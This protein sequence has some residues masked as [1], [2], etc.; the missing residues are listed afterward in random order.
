MVV[1]AWLL[2][3]FSGRRCQ[4]AG[5]GCGP[6]TSAPGASEVAGTDPLTGVWNCQRFEEG[7]AVLMALAVRTRDPLTL[8]RLELDRTPGSLGGA[9]GLVAVAGVLRSRIRASDTLTRCGQAFLVLAPG[10][11]LSGAK[12]LA[13]KLRAAISTAALSGQTLSIGVTEYRPGETLAEWTARAEQGSREAVQSGGNRVVSVGDAVLPQPAPGK[14]SAMVELKW[15]RGLECGEAVLDGQHHELFAMVNT[16]LATV[17][18][19]P[20][21][22]EVGYRLQLLQE[23]TVRHFAEEEEILARAGYPRL[24][25][26]RG[27]HRLLTGR[28]GQLRTALPEGKLQMGQLVGFL[29]VEFIRDHFFLEDRE[30]FPWVQGRIRGDQG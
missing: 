24:E 26:H 11:Y 20:E 17:A 9:E 5:G 21:A 13:Q 28:L 29:L 3:F 6:S 14:G 10:T 23:Y 12:A 7:A 8:L 19:F 18:A 27:M 4:R 22:Q 25:L 30:F 2:G 1:L 15:D 16:L